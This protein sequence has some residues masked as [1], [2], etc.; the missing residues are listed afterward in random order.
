MPLDNFTP[1]KVRAIR[2]CPQ[3]QHPGEVF[4]VTADAAAILVSIGVAEYVHDDPAK[5]AKGHYKRRDL[6]SEP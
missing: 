1:T 2:E 5:P 4:D 6:R 3:G